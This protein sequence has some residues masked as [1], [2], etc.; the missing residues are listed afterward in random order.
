MPS[1]PACG[2]LL[3]LLLPAASA[4][5]PAATLG[6][7]RPMS[8]ALNPA[9]RPYSVRMSADD[10]DSSPAQRVIAAS[11]ASPGFT[12]PLASPAPIAPAPSGSNSAA[13][14]FFNGRSRDRQTSNYEHQSNFGERI[15]E[16]LQPGTSRE[17]DPK[18][19][20]ES[21]HAFDYFIS[22][23][24]NPFLFEDPR[25]VTEL[26]P[27]FMYQSIPSGDVNFKGGNIEVYA[28]QARL[29]FSDRFSMTV[30]KLGFITVNPGSGSTQ[31]GGTSFAEF[32]L[33]PKFTFL[34]DT[35]NC[36]LGAAGLVF[37]IP[38][39]PA[40]TYQDTGSLSLVPY[41]TFAKN[42]FD[43]RFGSLNVMNTTGYS[44]ATDRQ[45][46][47]YLYNSFHVDWD[48][49]NRHRLYPL[50][51]F[52]YF[53][54]TRSGGARALNVEGRDLANFGDTN[55]AGNANVNIAIGARYKFSEGMQLGIATEF[56]L[57]GR[58]D[59]NDFRLTVDFIWRY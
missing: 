36:L 25:A 6:R 43:T 40:R 5:Q 38:D 15:M 33:A 57:N 50:M 3:A 47:D 55:S 20:F 49:A 16:F 9:D 44:F 31:P 27:I 29:A 45:R 41:V 17:C 53:Q 30:N 32:W 19:W 23:V 26:R 58:K 21:D 14:D 34:R 7:P 51:E 56:P 39:G 59:I 52:H 8:A 2:M 28:L 35:Q 11:S 12:P 13:E 10:M 46:S 37:Q 42:C 22:P 18:R 54:W 48:V 4:A 24:T 1:R